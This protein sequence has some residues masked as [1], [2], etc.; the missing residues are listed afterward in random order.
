[1]IQVGIIHIDDSLSRKPT[2][3]I[4]LLNRDFGPFLQP[5]HLGADFSP[6]F[7]HNEKGECFRHSKAPFARPSHLC[8]GPV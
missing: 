1:V 2:K 4:L 6:A 8:N 7:P 3:K 5:E